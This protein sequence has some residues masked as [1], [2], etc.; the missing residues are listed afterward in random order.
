M[1]NRIFDSRWMGKFLFA[2]EQDMTKTVPQPE[3]M[4]PAQ[5]DYPA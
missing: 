5:E 2:F 4:S 3:G 1:V